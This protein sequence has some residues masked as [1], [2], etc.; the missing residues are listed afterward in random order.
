M[1]MVDV[2]VH[3]LPKFG[4]PDFSLMAKQL[5]ARLSPLG[6]LP[7]HVGQPSDVWEVVRLVDGRAT[8]DPQ[9]VAQIGKCNF[10]KALSIRI[11]FGLE[12][13]IAS[14]LQTNINN[15]PNLQAKN[16][17]TALLL[18]VKQ[19]AN[20]HYEQYV[21]EIMAWEWDV[22]NALMNALPTQQKPTSLSVLDIKTAIGAM[23]SDWLLELEYRLR[24]AA[25]NWE[26]SDYPKI[27]AW[28][29]SQPGVSVFMPQG[30]A[31][32]PAPQKPASPRQTSFPSCRP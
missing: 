30:L 23:A 15:A 28:M 9:E 26:N 16:F 7:G 22:K 10:V 6:R 25:Y 14:E 32:P 2:E 24:V 19:H 1:D 12:Y 21:R 31:I 8:L 20:E 27:T 4:A 3:I 11:D 13:F 17:H 29:T 18:K 5:G